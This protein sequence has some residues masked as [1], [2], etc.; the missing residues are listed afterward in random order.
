MNMVSEEVR[1]IDKAVKEKEE[2]VCDSFL[3]IV[4]CLY[5]EHVFYCEGAV[6]NS[7][8]GSLREN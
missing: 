7:L 4:E 3:E 1:K 8:K 6:F 5:C 2:G